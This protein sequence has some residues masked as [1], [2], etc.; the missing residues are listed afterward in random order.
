MKTIDKIFKAIFITSFFGWENIKWLI[1]EFMKMYS[2]EKSYFSKKR[3]ESSIA[4]CS[5]IGVLLCY[6][7][8]HRHTLQ[9]SEMLADV[10]LLVGLAGYYVKKIQDEK[11]EVQTNKTNENDSAS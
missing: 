1:R 4:F 9:N 6:V 2:T 7:W 8:S 10:T 5:A 11:S 3:F